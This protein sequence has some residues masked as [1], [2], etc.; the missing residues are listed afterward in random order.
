MKIIRESYVK[1]IQKKV[2][3]ICVTTLIAVTAAAGGIVWYQAAQDESGKVSVSKKMDM[4]VSALISS[5]EP[6]EVT[7]PAV[8]TEEA[9]VTPE[10]VITEETV[11]PEPE[12]TPEPV[13]EQPVQEQPV[14]EQP[15]QEQPVE[16]QPVAEQPAAEEVY[17]PP[18][19]VYQQ[20]EGIFS[21]ADASYFDDALFIGD[22]RTEGLMAYGTLKNATYFADTGINAEQA[23]TKVAKQPGGMNLETLLRSRTFGKVYILFGINEISSPPEGIAA[24]CRRIAELVFSIQPDAIVYIQGNPHVTPSRNA[25]DSRFN[26]TRINAL[27]QQL[28]A[29]AN[30]SNMFYIDVNEIFDDE[31]GCLHQEYSSDGIHLKARYYADWCNW[32]CSHVVPR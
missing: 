7:E 15:V 21:T 29:L 6:Q 20:G 2:I 30:N 12:P 16:E 9:V 11:E 1:M 13:A 17:T 22:S 24:N 28:A 32:L 31:T 5:E 10:A 14:E 8:V 26:N 18:T 3:M 27:N 4:E 23:L 25:S 19:P